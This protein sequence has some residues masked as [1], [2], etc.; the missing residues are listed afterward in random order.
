MPIPELQKLR[1]KYPQY[2]DIDDATLANKIATKYPQYSDLV[3]KVGQVEQPTPQPSVMQQLG[4]AFKNT[5]ENI[6]NPIY[7]L[8][9]RGAQVAQQFDPITNMLKAT[10]VMK[11]EVGGAQTYK[12]PITGQVIAPYTNQTPLNEPIGLGLQ[13]AASFAAPTLGG[14]LAAGGSTMQ[15]GGNIGDILKNALFGAGFGKAVGMASGEPLLTGKVGKFAKT[16][17]QKGAE[18]SY[19]KA[20]GPTTTT[21]KVLASKVVPE[22]AER[23]PF[24]WSRGGLQRASEKKL[25]LASENL[26]KGYQ[27]LGDDAKISVN[28]ILDSISKKQE[29]LKINGV[30]P[31]ENT[32]LNSRLDSIGG[33]IIDIAKN[34][35][36]PLQVMRQYRQVLDNSVTAGKKV[37]PTSSRNVRMDAQRIAG[38]VIRKEIAKQHPSIGRLNSE[39]SFWNKMGDLLE[40]TTPKAKSPFN[41]VGA[42]IGNVSGNPAYGLVMRNIGT[43]FSDNVA[44][45]TLS[46]S[47][48]ARLADALTKG[49]LKAANFTIMKLLKPKK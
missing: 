49:D 22:L 7:E 36:A 28:P 23:K 41:K 33:A 18:K 5:G 30:L 8:G 32:A 38:N 17:L 47:T 42:A 39:F 15:Q 19:T 16:Q 12:N 34:D 29:A 2:N 26:E 24:V 1:E 37:F 35:E 25:Q 3:D 6:I 40:T 14:A 46:G 11:D 20:L 48:K 44:W 9:A 4:R 43:L 21:E 10:G 31:P 13:G 45:N 27:A